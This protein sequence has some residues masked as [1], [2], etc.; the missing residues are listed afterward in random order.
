M[1]DETKAA[2]PVVPAK[3]KAKKTAFTS[4]KR[5]EKIT[6]DDQEYVVVQMSGKEKEEWQE[7]QRKRFEFDL[8]NQSSL[9]VDGVGQA[10]ELIS[11]CV[12]KAMPDATRQKLDQAAFDK[13]W[14]CELVD[15]LWELCQ[16]VNGLNP[17][18]V[19]EAKNS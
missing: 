10:W 3:P 5:V 16:E 15:E 12:F 6:I 4:K 9:L 1:N 8:A 18:G 7:S 14:S 13:D 17:K 19:D 2:A 11:R